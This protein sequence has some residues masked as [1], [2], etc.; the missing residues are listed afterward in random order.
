MSIEPNVAR[1]SDGK[2]LRK[3]I[4]D[5]AGWIGV[6]LPTDT[7]LE[8]RGRFMHTLNG[9]SA[10][11]VLPPGTNWHREMVALGEGRTGSE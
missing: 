8:I 9:G 11:V 4:H 6:G 10:S 3:I 7:T 5:R 1:E 2:R